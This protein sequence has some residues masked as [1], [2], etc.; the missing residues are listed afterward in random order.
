MLRIE[1]S[2]N[3]AQLHWGVDNVRIL[4]IRQGWFDDFENPHELAQWRGSLEPLFTTHCGDPLNSILGGY[5]FAGVGAYLE[6]SYDLAASP[7]SIARITLDFIKIDSWDGEAAMLLVDGEEEWRQ[8]FSAADGEPLCGSTNPGWNEQVVKVAVKAN[9]DSAL[10]P[11]RL[12]TE[13]NSQ[14]TDESFGIDNVSVEPICTTQLV[15]APDGLA[16]ACLAS[17]VPG[18]GH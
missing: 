11:L 8:T 16:V 18:G 17:V 12:A 3:P 9:H 5:R 15:Y 7:H 13:L 14:A 1:V 10:L 6:R 2:P 4:P